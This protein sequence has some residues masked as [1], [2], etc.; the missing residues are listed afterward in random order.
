MTKVN[1]AGWTQE[2]ID[3]WQDPMQIGMQQGPKGSTETG[4]PWG[5]MLSNI[6]SGIKPSP[7]DPAM[8]GSL[9][10][11]LA[12][13]PSGEVKES[14]VEGGLASLPNYDDKFAGFDKQFEGFNKQIGGFDNQFKD[15]IGRLDKLEQGLGSFSGPASNQTP[16]VTG[17]TGI[18]S[19]YAG[20]NARGY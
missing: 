9:D 1:M 3:N 19:I 7:H 20:S 6:M 2:Q 4:L 18:G 13:Q 10:S 11:S 16:S 8:S 12:P 17:Q 5:G 15:I 14:I